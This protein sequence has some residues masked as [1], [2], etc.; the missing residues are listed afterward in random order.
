M[1]NC[2]SEGVSRALDRPITTL[3]LRLEAT[4]PR[5]GNQQ[6]SEDLNPTALTDT[7]NGY[8]VV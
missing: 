6:R 3:R 1:Q 7:E 5:I 2:T 8:D 4:L